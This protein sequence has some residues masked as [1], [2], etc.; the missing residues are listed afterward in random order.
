MPTKTA[1]K[2]LNKKKKG[3]AGKPSSF[4]KTIT[5]AVNRD[6]QVKVSFRLDKIPVKIKVLG[7][8]VKMKNG[9]YKTLPAVVKSTF[10]VVTDSSGAKVKARSCCKPPD[11]FDP[12]EGVKLALKRL[13]KV[14]TA[15][16]GERILSNS[17]RKLLMNAF[18]SFIFGKN[19]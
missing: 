5:T 12:R 19:K 1:E 9:K 7:H 16:G 6:L 8:N 3:W 14:D 15:R 13:F 11:V 10:I 4:S 18:W 2:R 17:D